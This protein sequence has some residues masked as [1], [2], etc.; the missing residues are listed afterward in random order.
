[1]TVVANESFAMRDRFRGALLGC[2]LGDGFG[3]VLEGI[4]ATD[5]RLDALLARRRIER[6]PWRYTDDTEMALGLA[7]SLIDCG[8]LDGDHLF[9]TWSD[10]YEPARGYGRG[11]KLAIQAWRAGA[12]PAESAWRDGSNGSGA[13]VR[14]VALACLLHRD[15]ASLDA[16]ARESAALTHRGAAG[17]D[18]CV[19]H[20]RALAQVLRQPDAAS[21]DAGAFVAALRSF[22]MVGDKV[23][24]IPSL[25]TMSPAVA[26]AELGNGLMADESVPLALFAFLR[27]SPQFEDVVVNTAR[28]GGD[29]DTIAAM[30]GAL[31]GAAVGATQLPPLWLEN[32]EG[33]EGAAFLADQLHALWLAKHRP[34]QLLMVEDNAAFAGVVTREFLSQ[35]EVTL[36]PGLAAARV[37]LRDSSSF[38]AVLVG[39]DLEDGKGDELVRELVS[40]GFRGRIVA[41]SSHERG[42]AALIDAGGHVAC[43][44]GQFAGIAA[45]LEAHR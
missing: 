36:V 3:S 17:M 12:S 13:A 34:L 32:A 35:H 41:I 28:C 27:W 44:K 31:T 4:S 9:Q 43:P 22:G 25:L 8:K 1:M 45:V 39:Y 24:R 14:V 15:H 2:L 18:G 30:S 20:A 19:L 29:V 42:N 40:S 7:R 26:A 11:M 6:Q 10:S 33:V 16:A 37:K 5:S 38:D 21:M 23:L